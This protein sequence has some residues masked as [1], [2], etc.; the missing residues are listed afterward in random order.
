MAKHMKNNH[1]IVND[2]RP[3]RS[4]LL[5]KERAKFLENRFR[6][7]KI[8]IEYHIDQEEDERRAPRSTSEDKY[9]EILSDK[10]IVTDKKKPARKQ[11]SVL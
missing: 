6:G 8:I 10:P 9:K 2:F 7:N 11:V 4:S 3:V 5:V 1:T